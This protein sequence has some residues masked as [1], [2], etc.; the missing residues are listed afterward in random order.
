MF[1]PLKHFIYFSI[2]KL[3]NMLKFSFLTKYFLIC[4]IP[5]KMPYFCL[6]GFFYFLKPPE[7]RF[8]LSGRRFFNGHFFQFFGHP[9]PTQ[10]HY[11][12]NGAKLTVFCGCEGSEGFY[13]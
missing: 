3:L 9:K 4:F 7:F 11:F 12:S 5:P 6:N 2:F 13:S 10:S 8:I 1:L